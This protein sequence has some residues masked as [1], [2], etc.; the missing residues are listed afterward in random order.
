LIN[1]LTIDVEDYFHVQ[2]FADVIPSTDWHRYSLR[3][4][5][6]TYRLLEMLAARN[7]HATFFVL[8]WVAQR[9]APLVADIL[10]A[11]HE[12]GSHGYA[13]QMI[14]RGRQKDF[15]EDV[16]RSK[17]ILEDQLGRAVKSYRAPSYSITSSTLWALE[18]LREA[19]FECDSSIFPVHHDNYGMPNAPRFPHYRTLRDGD[20]ILEFPPS[21]IE[22]CG[23]NFPMAGG[24][25]FRLLPYSLTAWAIRRI[26][27]KEKQPALLYFHPWEI[28]P[29]QPRIAASWRS[30]FRHYQNLHS[31]EAKLTRLFDDFSW[32]PMS[33][34]L[35]SSLGGANSIDE[36]A[37]GL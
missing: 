13:H 12:I 34:V 25:Y 16:R 19:G 1:A 26:N 37:D 32:A 22:A 4:E 18:I 20:R 29:E 10:K 23:V 15:R 2:A 27:E 17:S 28:D 21:T 14:A 35:V 5:E 36:V 24:G 30:R 33:K 11:G 31:T 6:N 3:V 7:I 8:G 9:C